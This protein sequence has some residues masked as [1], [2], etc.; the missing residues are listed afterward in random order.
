MVRAIIKK[1]IRKIQGKK[2][3]AVIGNQVD[4]ESIVVL[5]DLFN[6][7]GSDNFLCSQN[8][9]N[10]QSIPRI[11]YTFNSNINGIEES[12]FCLL[13]GT[14][15][16]TEA[17]ILNARIRKTFLSKKIPVFS[18]G[19]PGDLTYDYKVV[20][21]RDISDLDDKPFVRKRRIR[22]KKEKR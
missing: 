12:D 8:N 13:I 22:N 21:E 10:Y 19:S 4:C 1:K 3:A 6:M 7:L 15:P 5:K 16:R 20:G 17:T 9:A 18:I 11:A 14:N 2:I